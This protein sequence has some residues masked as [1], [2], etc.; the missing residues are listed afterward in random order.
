MLAMDMLPGL[1]VQL[2]CEASGTI[3]ALG[4]DVARSHPH[5]AMGAPICTAFV[6]PAPAPLPGGVSGGAALLPGLAASHIRV[7]ADAVFGAPAG[8]PLAEAAGLIVVQHTAY[9]ALIKRGALQRGE[10]ILIHSAAGG[11]GQAALRIA[12]QLGCRIVASAGS[13]AKREALAAMP[14][15][16]AVLNSRAIDAAAWRAAVDE[17]T[18]GKGVDVALNS[19]AGDG[20]AATLAQL[21]R[22]TCTAPDWPLD[23]A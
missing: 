4:A 20:I 18:G 2:G 7:P 15:V 17:A 5:L 16:V 21:V 14:G 23:A 8:L 9:Y 13:A 6:P 11:L 19:L 3:R 12:Q 1:P 10:S 22:A